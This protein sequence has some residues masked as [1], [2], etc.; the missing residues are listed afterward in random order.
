MI[1]LNV[2]LP[3]KSV[4]DRIQSC[5]TVLWAIDTHGDRLIDN[6]GESFDLLLEEHQVT[7]FETQLAL[8]KKKLILSRDH[9]ITCDRA[10][11]DQRAQETLFRARRDDQVKVV[12]ADVVGLH[13]VFT[14]NYSDA[15]LAGFGFAR[16]VPQQPGELLE[17]A[18]HLA[19]RLCDPDLDL[20]GARFDAL[21]FEAA[22]L[23]QK[24]VQEV[25]PLERRIDEL[26]REERQTEASKLAK[27]DALEAYNQLFLN[28][29]RTVE[30]LFRLAGLEEVARRIRPS[31]TR[32]GVTEGQVSESDDGESEG[33]AS[34]EAPT[35]DDAAEKYEEEIADAT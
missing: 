30:S 23:A 13:R 5:R 27:D 31:A 22:E 19:T 28:F 17:Q 8:F 16:R 6:L 11:R 1:P 32:P 15:K 25:G 12:N 3:L 18:S 9:L 2:N 29:A 10:Y 20:S 4:T 7:P 35:D 26:A 14:G 33:D 34:A 24:L 21:K